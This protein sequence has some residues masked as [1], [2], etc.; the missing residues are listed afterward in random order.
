MLA[1]LIDSVAAAPACVTVQVRES[2]PPAT[3]TAPMRDT[4]AGL[5]ATL[6][7]TVPLLTPEL[8]PVTAIHEMLDTAVHDMFAV[9]LMVRPLAATLE[10]LV[11]AGLM[12]SDA[13][14]PACVTEQVREIPP[15]ATITAPVREDVAGL[16]VTLSVTVPLLVPERPPVTAIHG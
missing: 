11:F 13:A 6:N 12:T 9:T 16:V 5:V 7:V 3:M 15:P 8:P 4:V 10:K 14:A 1:G 2:P